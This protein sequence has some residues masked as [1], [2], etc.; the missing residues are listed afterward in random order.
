MDLSIA[1]AGNGLAPTNHA[2]LGKPPRISK[3]LSELQCEGNG[4]ADG[5]SFLVVQ[6]RYRGGG[7]NDS[8]IPK[9]NC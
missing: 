1:I 3:G 8:D 7:P 9:T 5:A 4:L 2:Q 6:P